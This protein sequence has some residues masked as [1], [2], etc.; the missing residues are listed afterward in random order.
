MS[1]KALG[2]LEHIVDTLKSSNCSPF[3]FLFGWWNFSMRRRL[4]ILLMNKSCCLIGHKLYQLCQ[5]LARDKLITICMCL[6]LL[7]AYDN[8]PICPF[9]LVGKH[10][11]ILWWTWRREIGSLSET[12]GATK[13]SLSWPALE[14]LSV[15]GICGGSLTSVPKV[16]EVKI[17][18]SVFISSKTFQ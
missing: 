10:K 14:M 7:Q 2:P 11:T 4:L 17:A 16:G 3:G 6:L 1:C 8:S 12:D 18:C 15:S 9:P 13:C 5:M